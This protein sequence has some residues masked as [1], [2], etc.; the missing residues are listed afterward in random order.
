[1]LKASISQ[2]GHSGLEGVAPAQLRQKVTSK[3]GV[4]AA[5]VGVLDAERVMETFVRALRDGRDRGGELSSG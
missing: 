2:G 5:A 4:T 3:G 1:M